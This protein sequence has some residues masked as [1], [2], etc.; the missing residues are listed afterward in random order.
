LAIAFSLSLASEACLLCKYHIADEHTVSHLYFCKM[1]KLSHFWN[2]FNH[3]PREESNQSD[4]NSSTQDEDIHS[5]AETDYR[6]EN[7]DSEEEAE[8]GE[9]QLIRL[10]H[11]FKYL[12]MVHQSF[13]VSHCR[14][15]LMT[16]VP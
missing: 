10:R 9:Y 1:F 14:V 4:S 8:Q 5:L 15:A 11:R 2:P 7:T 6:S 3:P 12:E 16:R 13:G